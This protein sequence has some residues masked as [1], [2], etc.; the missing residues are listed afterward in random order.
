[1]AKQSELKKPFR[2]MKTS[3]IIAYLRASSNLSTDFDMIRDEAICRIL[4]RL[5]DADRK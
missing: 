5:D 1:M 2:K 3:Q 4:E